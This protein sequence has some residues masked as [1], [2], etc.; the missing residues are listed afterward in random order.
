MN[1]VPDIASYAPDCSGHSMN[2][3]SR[4]MRSRRTSSS[5]KTR[6][7]TINSA[8]VTGGRL[9]NIGILGASA[10]DKAW[11][12]ATLPAGP[13]RRRNAVGRGYAPDTPRRRSAE[14]HDPRILGV[15]GVA[16]T[17]GVRMR[18]DGRSPG[19]R[20]PDHLVEARVGLRH[21]HAAAFDH[22]ALGAQPLRLLAPPAGAFREGDAA[23]AA[24]DAV[25]GQFRILVAA[26]DPRHQPRP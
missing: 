19:L 26:Q 20:A 11:A 21:A 2:G 24:Q 22:H 25:P 17:Y 14:R 13:G 5:R 7:L 23:V 4:P 18:G 12:G 15:G 10:H 1:A 3:A 6:P 8:L 9:V 16:P